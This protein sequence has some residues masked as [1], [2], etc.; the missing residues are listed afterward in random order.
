MDRL[1]HMF[2]AYELMIMLSPTV[3]KKILSK[4]KFFERESLDVIVSFKKFISIWVLIKLHNWV[5]NSENFIWHFCHQACIDNFR[6]FVIKICSLFLFFLSVN[7]DGS[8]GG[9]L[10]LVAGIFCFICESFW[11]FS[12]HRG[13]LQVCDNLLI[14]MDNDYNS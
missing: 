7:W 3:G 13:W 12:I 4:F 14:F 1:L 9:D 2:M 5:M 10:G 8:F 11:S 6:F